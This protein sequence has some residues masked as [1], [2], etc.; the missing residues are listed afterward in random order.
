MSWVMHLFIQDF[1]HEMFHVSAKLA[2]Y[3]AARVAVGPEKHGL[4]QRKTQQKMG[5]R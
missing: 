3:A 2:R 1:A 5:R 4:Q